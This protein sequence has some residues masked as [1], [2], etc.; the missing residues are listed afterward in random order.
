MD[1]HDHC[2]WQLGLQVE[3]SQNSSQ[4][5]LFDPFGTHIC[6]Y[7]HCNVWLEF[8]PFVTSGWN[9]ALYF[10][11]FLYIIPY[12]I[13]TPLSLYP[14]C[15][16]PVPLQEV[17]RGIQHHD[18]RVRSH[19]PLCLLKGEPIAQR[20]LPVR[21]GRSSHQ[22]EPRRPQIHQ[23]RPCICQGDG[24]ACLPFD[25]RN[26]IRPR[27]VRDKGLLAAARSAASCNAGRDRS[28]TL[29]MLEETADEVFKVYMTRKTKDGSGPGDALARLMLSP[30]PAPAPPP[31]A[32]GAALGRDASASPGT[33]S[34]G[35]RESLRP[36]HGGDSD[37]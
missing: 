20:V 24:P 21:A 19:A 9:P 32:R 36:R 37:D 25:S 22:P 11:G 23:C 18:R 4:R 12:L 26:G 35:R 27:D 5:K 7:H 10:F 3:S 31:T 8:R 1:S 14:S 29:T 33:C 17:P 6:M 34:V 16:R 13:L 30:S 2:A 15:R 28:A